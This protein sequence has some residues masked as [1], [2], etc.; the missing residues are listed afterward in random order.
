MS[1][2]EAGLPITG[3]CH[4][5]AIRY[6]ASAPPLG[7]RSCWCRFCQ[8]IASGSAAVNI[9]FPASAVTVTGPLQTF[10]RI[11]DSGNRLTS[12]FCP[13]CGTQV[14]SFAEA[15]P[16]LLLLRAG[17]LDDPEAFA[18]QSTIWTDSAPRWA[19]IDA[20]LPSY[21][22]QAPPLG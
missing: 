16:H 9:A 10:E 15:R 12:G 11:A 14:S 1:D 5:G 19:L 20:A 6:E 8:S 7:A 3:G 4:C 13:V 22:R 18:P 2:G 17:T 21:P